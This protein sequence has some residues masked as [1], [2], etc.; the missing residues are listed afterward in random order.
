MF[1]PIFKT[2]HQ[3]KLFGNPTHASWDIFVNSLKKTPST[4]TIKKRCCVSIQPPDQYGIERMN[5]SPNKTTLKR[6]NT[7]ER[8][9]VEK[10]PKI[11]REAQ[12]PYEVNIS[13]NFNSKV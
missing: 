1:L 8:H 9:S 3:N 10:L 13:R 5:R 7:E 11:V 2:D 6:L 4:M 12:D